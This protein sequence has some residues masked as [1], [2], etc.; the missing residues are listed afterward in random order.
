MAN[1]HNPNPFD[2]VPFAEKP[3]LKHE[4]EFDA[5][6]E[7]Y[8]G[9]LE[10][11]IKALTPIH[12]V[13][14]QEPCDED[15]KDHKDRKSFM[16][17][18]GEDACIPAGTIRGCLRSF[19]EALTSGWV[20]QANNEYKKEYKKRHIGF[21]TFEAHPGTEQPPAVDPQYKPKPLQGEDPLLDVASYLFG[22]VV[23][24]EG[25]QE[26]AHESLARK[27]RVWVE[28]AYIANPNLDDDS[29]WVPDIYGTAFMGGAKP[30]A[31]SWWY[32]KPKPGLSR[33]R[34]VNRRGRHEVAEF[35]GDKFWGR[36]F[37][38]HQDPEK[39]VRYYEP[40]NKTWPYPK[41]NFCKVH[42]ECL[43]PTTST[44]TFRIY[45]DRIPRQI[46]MLLVMSIFPG[47]NIRHKIGYGKP[48]GFGSIE[49][50]LEGAHMRIDG[51]DQR[52][53]SEL[54]NYQ[55]QISVWQ[56][57]SWDKTRMTA[58]GLTLDLI[59]ENVLKHLAMILGWID[60]DKILFT[61]PPFPKGYLLGVSLEY[62]SDLQ[63]GQ[64]SSRLRSTLKEKGLI[65]PEQVSVKKKYSNG[66]FIGWE[67][68]G[69]KSHSVFT[70]KEENKVL[71]VYAPYS[72]NTFARPISYAD[73]QRLAGGLTDARDVADSLW[74]IKKPLHFRLYQ[75][76]SE[77]WDI[78]QKRKP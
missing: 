73:F 66:K 37:Y 23:E 56:N 1:K 63:S 74:G 14:Y 50:L 57:L 34:V 71:N 62:K 61:Y 36:K 2:F 43:R 48:Y 19:V 26:I 44:N 25:T 70:V 45:V 69:D 75:E 33:K 32:L 39:C 52:I 22:I 20:S 40:Q 29:Y 30:S 9:Y 28:D 67:I 55:E 51:K 4:S 65:F 17:R 3:L 58:A 77:G 76:R 8:S 68:R 46:L 7:M 72:E 54:E 6:G 53:P 42:I 38:F 59:D 35:L 24:K 5:M 60:F 16:Y 15:C 47:H 41:D 11:R 78:I 49:F 12:V 27:S 64:F 18:Q 10:L 21:R 13:G 31:S